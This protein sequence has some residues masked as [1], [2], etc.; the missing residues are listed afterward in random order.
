[1]GYGREGVLGDTVPRNA[2]RM[3]AFLSGCLPRP[4]VPPDLVGFLRDARMFETPWI[5]EM[6][7]RSFILCVSLNRSSFVH[8]CGGGLAANS[9]A[10]RFASFFSIETEDEACVRCWQFRGSRR[11]QDSRAGC[12]IKVGD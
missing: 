7:G 8:N 11:N 9:N 4:F 2:R 10:V 6:F 3:E 1:V 12:A 5:A